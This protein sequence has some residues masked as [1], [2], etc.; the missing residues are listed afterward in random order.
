MRKP[1]VGIVLIS[2][3]TYPCGI[4]MFY[5]GH[6]PISLKLV[7]LLALHILAGIWPDLMTEHTANPEA[8]GF[9]GHSSPPTIRYPT[10]ESFRPSVSEVLVEG[11]DKAGT[12]KQ[13]DLNTS[14]GDTEKLPIF[15]LIS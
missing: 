4:R 14:I 9:A 8:G 15:K 13:E 3:N 6:V 2:R 7:H 5:K 10:C 1:E 12:A 11:N